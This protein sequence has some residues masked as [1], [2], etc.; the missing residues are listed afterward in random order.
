MRVAAK[1]A[2]LFIGLVIAELSTS[3]AGDALMES[4]RVEEYQKRNYSW[5]LNNYV[6]NTRGWRDLMEERLAQFEEMEDAAGRYQGYYQTIYSAASAPNFTEFGF[7]LAKCPDDLLAALQ[8]G[9]HD[10]LP[11]AALETQEIVN[12]PLP[13]LFINRYDLTKRVLTEL[14]SYAE[15][16]AS[17]PLTAHQAYGFRLYRNQ[18]QVRIVCII[19][20]V[21]FG[22]FEQCDFTSFNTLSL[23]LVLSDYYIYT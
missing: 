16:W 22:Q 5:P 6:P 9:I 21:R 7:G 10:G 19:E 3:R 11:T 15:E 8:K 23:F 2:F 17:V 18:S 13:P 4:E 1:R 20:F 14:H 12:A